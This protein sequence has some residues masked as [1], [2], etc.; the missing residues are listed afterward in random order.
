MTRKFQSVL[1]TALLTVALASLAAPP[2]FT[3]FGSTQTNETK[4]D[5]TSSTEATTSGESTDPI[6]DII[7]AETDKDTSQKSGQEP[8]KEQ[9]SDKSEPAKKSVKG[10]PPSGSKRPGPKVV[11]K[12]KDGSSAT[13]K[14]SWSEFW[15]VLLT[16]KNQQRPKE[17]THKQPDQLINTSKYHKD[18]SQLLQQ[19]DLH[20]YGPG[21]KG[22]WKVEASEVLCSMRQLIPGY[23]Y[24]EFRQ[25]IGRP[26]EFVLYVTHPPAGVG[27]AHLR[28]EPAAWQHY[29]KAKDLGTIEVDPGERAVIATSNWSHR[30]LLELAQGMQPKMS[31]WD[32]ADATDDIEVILS[33]MNFQNSL[34][35]FHACLE[36]VL[37]YDFASVE[38]T[39]VAFNP[40]SSRLTR[41]ALSKMAG[42]L[43]I[44][45]H[46][47][48]IK[49]VELELYTHR[50]G[51]VQYNFRLATRRARAIRDYFLRKGIR[52]NKLIIK[53]RTYNKAKLQRLGYSVHDV[54]ILL[55][56]ENK[57]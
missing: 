52:D 55:I 45:E 28:V 57:K 12:D 20:R 14:K 36:K 54:H 27:K 30:L 7:L 22:F 24:V 15:A 31:Y 1:M 2:R 53:I 10:K 38:R 26:L 5:K 50:K 35:R 46:D 29:I 39:L 49:R 21:L 6:K 13:K 19:G 37:R 16:G 32:S 51:L 18:T 42:V 4:T 44:L 17:K 48:D 34:Q 33:A 56:Y 47:K 9:V 8:N 40:D 3:G 11:T 41:A 25:G 23:G 43:E